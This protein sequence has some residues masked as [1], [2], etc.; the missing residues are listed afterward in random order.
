M[1]ISSRF[2][3]PHGCGGML[4]APQWILTAAHCVEGFY[5][6]T[7]VLVGKFCRD[8]HNC[9]Q[10]KESFEVEKVVK[11]PLFNTPISFAHD[12][13][14]IK[15]FGRS[16]IT[17]I[18]MDN[19]YSQ[20]FLNGRSNIMVIGFGDNVYG[21]SEYFPTKLQEVEVKYVSQTKCRE[22]QGPVVSDDML[23]AGEKGEGSCI[24]DSGGPVWD[25]EKNIVIGVTSWSNTCTKPTNIIYPGK[26]NPIMK[27]NR[28]FYH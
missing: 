17:P 18:A 26:Y 9:N 24:G 21:S 15:I 11:D 12:I 10:I 16:T 5:L 8:D 25:A 23:C 22:I 6:P 19:G 14:L 2:S 4:V 27:N 28:Y 1:L 13:A 7:S 3:W 20:H